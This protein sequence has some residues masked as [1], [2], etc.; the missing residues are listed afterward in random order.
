[1]MDEYT[2]V[3][4]IF[5]VLLTAVL[6]YVVHKKLNYLQQTNEQNLHA[7]RWTYDKRRKAEEEVLGLG[8]EAHRK[9]THCRKVC[10]SRIAVEE[11]A[12]YCLS[13]WLS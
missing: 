2:L 6:A 3:A 13:G 1:M 12:I 11:K 7:Y 4:Q 5:Q 8:A 10:S 9:V